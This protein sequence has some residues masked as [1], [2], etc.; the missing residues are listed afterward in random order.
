MGET[1][2]K[3]H[4][5]LMAGGG[6]VKAY[7]YHIGVLKG[8]EQ[9]GFVFR[10]GPRWDPRCGPPGSRE[11][12][13]YVGSSAG[14]CVLAP[15]A[16]GLP[17]WAFEAA[18]LGSHPELPPF[19]YKTLFVPIAPNPVRYTRRMI[20][21]FRMG[22]LKPQHL[23]DVGGLFT[24]AGVE[25][26][27]RHNGLPT[28]RFSDLAANLFITATQVNTSRNVAFGPIDSLTASGYDQARAYYNNV[29]ISQAVAAAIAVPP[30]FAPYG[31]INPATGKRFYYYDGEVRET[32]STH[33]AQEAGANFVITSS[34]WQPYSY[35][36]RVGDLSRF[37][38]TVLTEQAL[39]QLIEQK[40]F[41]S[42][43]QANR[44]NDLLKLVQTHDAKHRVPEQETEEFK[45]QICQLLG[46]RP[47]K[48]FY[49]TPDPSDHEFFFSG[50]FRFTRSLIKR[51]IAA[52]YRA[53]QRSAARN[54]EFFQALDQAL[55]DSISQP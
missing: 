14:A 50:S 46:H 39:H 28:N 10:S 12:R 29:R 55:A 26:Y 54:Q 1:P 49:I 6:A 52:G 16:G 33:I 51:C 27:F 18:V 5:A 34:I 17:P 21:R 3:P 8:L 38:M 13:T 31:I 30:I 22:G 4:I 45:Q 9:D 41:Q 24:T 15:L 20:R 40:V 43:R 32:L 35:D 42:R 19:R 44:F 25:R 48:T 7:A 53:Y 23:L 2:V 36:H 11:I 37:G 47:I